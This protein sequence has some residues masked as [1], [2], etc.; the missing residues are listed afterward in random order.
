MALGD[1]LK[2]DQVLPQRKKADKTAKPSKPVTAVL[3]NLDTQYAHTMEALIKSQAVIEFAIDGTILTANDNFLRILGYELKEIQG[4]HHRMF[5]K[6]EYAKSSEYKQFWAKLQKGG[7]NS[8]QFKRITKSG[9]EVW[10]QA[11][12]NAILDENNN[13]YKVIKFASNITEQKSN[14]LILEQASKEV[15]DRQQVEAAHL[16]QRFTL[17][18]GTTTEGLWDMAVPESMEFKDE[19]PFWWANRF[20]QMLG[21]STE[22]DFPNRLDSWANLLHP[23]HKEQTLAAF[24]AHL[25]DFSGKTPYDVEYQLKLKNGQ[26][27]WFR[28][29]GNTLRDKL[30][31][32]LRVAGTLIDIQNSKDLTLFSRNWSQKLKKEPR[33]WKSCLPNRI[34]KR[35]SCIRRRKKS[36][37]TWKRCRLHKKRWPANN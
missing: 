35:K 21:Y 34:N 10:I 31:K 4:K 28:A 20:R 32:P 19:T 22:Q 15:L 13:P 30:G 12:Y 33:R 25:M 7:F 5:C 9:A 16:L 8:G 36:V 26:Y 11:T 27:R 14:E 1:N 2:S 6:A 3:S 37:R 23:D 17:V 29:V 24:N 18:T